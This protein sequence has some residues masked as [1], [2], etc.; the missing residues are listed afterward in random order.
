MCSRR[1]NERKHRHVHEHAPLPRPRRRKFHETLASKRIIARRV[2]HLVAL[3]KRKKRRCLSSR[4]KSTWDPDE[5]LEKRTEHFANGDFPGRGFHDLRSRSLW[6][7]DKRSHYGR[8]S[9][10]TF[11]NNLYFTNDVL[12]PSATYQGIAL[13]RSSALARHF[14]SHSSLSC[15]PRLLKCLSCRFPLRHT[16]ILHS[17]SRRISF[18]G[19]FC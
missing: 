10:L 11:V 13:A 6:W 1:D 12:H 15:S 9:Y 16:P 3:A 19:V 2:A 4:E 8:P 17:Y 5:S 18:K 14:S 7:A